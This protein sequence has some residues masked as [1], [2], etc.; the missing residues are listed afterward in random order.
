MERT[1][2][3]C[4]IDNDITPNKLSYDPPKVW[5]Y[6]FGSV[7]FSQKLHSA[8]NISPPSIQHYIILATALVIELSAFIFNGKAI[9]SNLSILSSWSRFVKFSRIYILFSN[10]NL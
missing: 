10:S 9:T 7:N 8:I 1:N 6:V 3:E 4:T 2:Y 5:N